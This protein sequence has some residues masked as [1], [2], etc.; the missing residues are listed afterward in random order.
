VLGLCGNAGVDVLAPVVVAVAVE[1]AAVD[2]EVMPTEMSTPARAEMTEDISHL[3]MCR[4]RQLVPKALAV[5]PCY[6]TQR[7][8]L[9]YRDCIKQSCALYVGED[10]CVSSRRLLCCECR[11][12]Q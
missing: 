10:C 1:G 5:R 3:W 9:N 12:D 11:D 2:S 7:C 8:G 6:R 4:L